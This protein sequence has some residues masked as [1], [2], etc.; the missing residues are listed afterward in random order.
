M[1]VALVFGIDVSGCPESGNY[2][3]MAV[4]ICTEEFLNVVVRR[5]QLNTVGGGFDT[6]KK[7]E[8]PYLTLSSLIHANVL[9]CIKTERKKI[10]QIVESEA[11]ADASNLLTS[12]I[13]YAYHQAVW[14]SVRGRIADFLKQHKQDFDD[15][16]FESDGDCVNF[17][18]DVAVRRTE[19]SYAHMMADAIAWANN[20][21]KAPKGVI[22]I[23]AT[24]QI[25]TALRK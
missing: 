17:L 9:L 14:R 4:F 7:T 24:G 13:R 2:K 12:K 6:K 15:A 18:K 10:L 5:L 23:D 1:A 8:N 19:P 3:Y 25:V 20:A 22:E 21:N 11:K 16:V